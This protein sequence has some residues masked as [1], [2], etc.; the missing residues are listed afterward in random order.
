ME[1]HSVGTRVNRFHGN[2]RHRTTNS[3]Y[4]NRASCTAM[5]K[6]GPTISVVGF[7]ISPTTWYAFSACRESSMI[8]RVRLINLVIYYNHFTL[9][10]D[11]WQRTCILGGSLASSSVG[12]TLHLSPPERMYPSWPRCPVV[13]CEEGERVCDQG[14]PH[15]VHEWLRLL[16]ISNDQTRVALY[17]GDA[18]S[19]YMDTWCPFGFSVLRK[20]LV[21]GWRIWPKPTEQGSNGVGCIE[22]TGLVHHLWQVLICRHGYWSARRWEAVEIRMLTKTK[23]P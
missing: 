11:M 15:L 19:G 8:E 13:W 1:E 9:G 23:Q 17:L 18:S 6:P 10:G 21:I 12:R 5:A 3:I 16:G 4:N 22:R 14:L 20:Y 7:V 2:G